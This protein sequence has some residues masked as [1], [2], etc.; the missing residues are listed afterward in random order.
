VSDENGKLFHANIG[1]E[2]IV[3]GEP[4]F[5]D[6]AIGWDSRA[7]LRLVKKTPPK[8]LLATFLSLTTTNQTKSNDFAKSWGPLNPQALSGL[9]E[10]LEANPLGGLTRMALSDEP[11]PQGKWEESHD[12]WV[13]TAETFR[14]ILEISHQLLEGE[15]TSQAAWQQLYPSM[16][17]TLELP[18]LLTEEDDFLKDLA[19]KTMWGRLRPPIAEL[20]ETA[21][22][23]PAFLGLD[24]GAPVIA[25]VG[26]GLLA[27]LTIQ[28]LAALSRTHLPVAC[29]ECAE[30]F[31]PGRRPRAGQRI[32]CPLCR[33][34]KAPQRAASRKLAGVKDEAFR[35]ADTGKNATQIAE[36]L[37][38]S[39]QQV[40]GWL[41]ARRPKFKGRK[42]GAK[43]VRG[44][45]RPG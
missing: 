34:G 27:H 43:A 8:D 19:R 4:M 18:D 28:L 1:R 39:P 31:Q 25:I 17:D 26:D 40:T 23:R 29:S 3:P 2:L 41:A 36:E 33:K 15:E 45:T 6:N 24:K 35:L 38:R 14:A 22:V 44:E 20:I 21:N 16:P 12:Y 30:Y 9:Y 42:R 7:G 10:R 5:L 37:D 32:Y 13:N 11:W